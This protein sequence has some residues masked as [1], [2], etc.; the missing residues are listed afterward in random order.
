MN[1]LHSCRRLA[2]TLVALLMIGAAL[3]G[4]EARAQ[5]NDGSAL[6][7]EEAQLLA[8]ILRDDS[9]RDALIAQLEKA[10]EEAAPEPEQS[11]KSISRQI[12][13]FTTFGAE[14]IEEVI[15]ATTTQLAAMPSLLSTLNAEQ[16]DVLWS[17][18]R[19]LAVVIVVTTAIFAGLRVIARRVYRQLGEAA[20]DASFMHI[21]GALLAS[22]LIDAI[23][24]LMAWGAG[25][26]AVLLIFDEVG[27]RQSLY[28]NAFLIVGMVKVVLRAIL[29]PSTAHLRLIAIPDRGA[30]V[31][32]RWLGV[33]VSVLGY[34][35]LVLVPIV[36]RQVSG[37]AGRGVSAIA[38]M[39]AVIIAA[40]LVIRGRR[41]VAAWILGEDAEGK[42]GTAKFLARN[43]H[44]PVLIYLLGLLI[45]VTT[46][47]D[48]L[49]WP[50]LISSANVLGVI[51]GGVLI[52]GAITRF[53]AR[54]IS[55]PQQ[56]TNNLPMLQRR[57]NTFVPR[58]LM[59]VRGL[60]IVG[61]FALIL[62]AI[63]VIDFGAWL[64]GDAGIQLTGTVVSVLVILLFSFLVWITLVSWIDYRLN[65]EIGKRPTARETTLLTLLK[66][67]ASIVLVI[68]TTMFVLSE[69]GIDIA[70]LIA[71]AGVLGLAIGFG[72]QKMVQDIITGIFIQFENAMNV[73]D[74]VT[75]GGTTGVVEKLTI[76]SVSLRDVDGTFHIIPFSSVDMV[77]NYMR[78]YGNFVCD[79]GI[80]Y[81]ESVSDAKQAMHDAFDELK[82]DEAVTDNIMGDLQWFGVQSLGDSAVVLRARIKCL[83]GTQWATGRAYNEICKRIFDERDIEI[84]FPHQTVYFGVDKQGEAPPLRIHTDTA[85]EA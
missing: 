32:A 26:L 36:N 14:K 73:G 11:A 71:S 49:I 10:G 2:L 15:K 52:S 7:P 65:I 21:V 48:G 28:L 6:P 66:N 40:V 50:V 80:G 39:I 75:L 78:D 24:V 17:A 23:V 83:P 64:E 12:A 25:Y 61:A 85:A 81:R 56:I 16:L 35:Q 1:L 44:I 58:A 43:W 79:M 72:A 63:D 18:L 9:K 20:H 19:A 13:E 27:V 69:I 59:I 74:V 84:P 70:P 29:S 37:E 62:D 8:D 33:I 34:G 67:A 31:L 57:L 60:I 82:A 47:P 22:T 30:K 41:A 42:R 54:G 38:A 55:L 5:S 51:V 76:R 4:P 77:S 3:F 46:R 68:I 45:V 53:S